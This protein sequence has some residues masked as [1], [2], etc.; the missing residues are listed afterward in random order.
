MTPP[1]DRQKLARSAQPVILTIPFFL[2]IR[3]PR[4]LRRR[5]TSRPA[6]PAGPGQRPTFHLRRRQARLVPAIRPDARS[7][8]DQA[9][10]R[11]RVRPGLPVRPRGTQGLPRPGPQGRPQRLID[12]RSSFARLSRR[13]PLPLDRGDV[14]AVV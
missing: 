14:G 9:V 8:L 2:Q 10:L 5:R 12:K 1:P 4:L 11:R 6:L 7:G 13:N 3:L